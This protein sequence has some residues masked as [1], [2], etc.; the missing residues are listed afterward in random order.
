MAP[1][2][3]LVILRVPLAKLMPILVLL[4]LVIEFLPEPNVNVLQ[5]H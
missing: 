5:D 3:L 2:V 1:P 4:V